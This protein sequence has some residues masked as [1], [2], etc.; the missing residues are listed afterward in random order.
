MRVIALFQSEL[1]REKN[2]DVHVL[3]DNKTAVVSAGSKDQ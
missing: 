3:R 1:G 2:N